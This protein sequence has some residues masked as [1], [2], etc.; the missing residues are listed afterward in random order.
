M[1]VRSIVA[2][3]VAVAWASHVA[4][5]ASPRRVDSAALGTTRFLA[6]WEIAVQD[7]DVLER[8]IAQRTAGREENRDAPDWRGLA[9]RLQP[10]DALVGYVQY[11]ELPTPLS[12]PAPAAYL[13]FVLRPGARSPVVVPVG[14][15]GQ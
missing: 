2:G 8:E 13:A 15:A 10:D 5:R 1:K 14:S 12:G 4:W 9:A 11:D 3:L 6:S 7:R